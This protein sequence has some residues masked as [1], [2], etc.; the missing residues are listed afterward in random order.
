MWSA[1][2]IIAHLHGGM[3]EVWNIPVKAKRGWKGLTRTYDES[4][5][6]TTLLTANRCWS[7]RYR[8]KCLGKLKTAHEKP[9]LLL[10]C[11]SQP[12]RNL[13]NLPAYNNELTVFLLFGS[14]MC[15]TH[16]YNWSKKETSPPISPHVWCHLKSQSS[17]T[18]SVACSYYDK[19]V[20][21]YVYYSNVVHSPSC[22]SPL[23]HK[24][25]AYL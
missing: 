5:W 1:D 25:H 23:E 20:N 15:C 13:P 7:I 4:M 22:F 17:S 14:T 21:V 16:S 12:F 9:V 8:T 19:Y 3:G 24:K 10:L 6:K 11:A 18:S 2:A